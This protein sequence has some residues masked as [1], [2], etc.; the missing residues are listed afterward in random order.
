M[1]F[2]TRLATILLA[3][4]MR[5]QP[6]GARASISPSPTRAMS[7]QLAA[8]SMITVIANPPRLIAVKKFA[9]CDKSPA[10]GWYL[11]L[12]EHGPCRNFAVAAGKFE[13]IGATRLVPISFRRLRPRSCLSILAAAGDLGRLMRGDGAQENLAELLQLR[14]AH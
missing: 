3:S 7:R 14:R 4:A 2:S 8:L 5:S 9:P 12:L 1:P 13:N 11:K 6:A 10:A